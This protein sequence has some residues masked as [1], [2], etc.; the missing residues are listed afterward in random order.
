MRRRDSRYVD[1]TIRTHVTG[2]MCSNAPT[3]HL[4]TY[5]DF[6]RVGR[7][8]YRFT[9][10]ADARSGSSAQFSQTSAIAEESLPKVPAGDS[11]VQRHAETI[12]LQ[13]LA[14]QLGFALKPERIYLP[15]GS[16]VEVDGVSHDPAMLVEVW[17]HQGT[18][19]P[20]QRNKV[21]SDALKL[22]Y[23]GS[24]LDGDYRLVLCLTDASAAAPFLGRSWYSGALQRARIE[25]EVVE[26]P[27][28][29]RASIRKAQARQSR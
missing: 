29:L 2:L 5:P 4:T 7:G 16:H 21:L 8:R 15:A 14:S 24:V 3:N 23:L 19:K 11:A 28:E 26:I 10:T 27:E 22:Q 18:L 1:S 25:V 20:A 9:S 13:A 12:A 6:E 17:A